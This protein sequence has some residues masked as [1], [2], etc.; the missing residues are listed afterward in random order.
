MYFKKM[1]ALLYPTKTS[2]IITKDIFRRVA[3]DK[4]I[5][6]KVALSSYYVENG[7]TPENLSYNLYGSSQYH[8]V[9][10][11]VNNIVS[12]NGEWPKDE[13]NMFAYVENKYGTGNA[14]EVHH[15]RIANSSPEIIVD[16]DAAK[17]TAGTHVSVTNYD[18]E[19]ELNESKR[20][21]QILKPQYLKDFITTYKKLMAN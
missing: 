15:Y 7:N 16:Y 4:K 20:Q 5:N 2:Q 17:L 8:W 6:T 18:Y 9:I 13:A 21:I 14:T 1:P 3:M 10:L 12:V 11:I 19:I